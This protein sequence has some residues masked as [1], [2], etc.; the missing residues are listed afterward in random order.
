MSH[1]P[2]ASGQEDE[3]LCQGP[4]QDALVCT[5][6][7]LTEPLFTIL[8]KTKLWLELK[9]GGASHLTKNLANP[10]QVKWNLKFSAREYWKLRSIQISG[11]VSTRPPPP[12]PLNPFT[13]KSDQFHIFPAA[14]P[15]IL[16]HTVWRTWRFMAYLDERW[17]YYQF[18]VAS[19]IHFS[20]G[21]L[22]ECTTVFELGSET[23]KA[24]VTL[25]LN[26]GRWVTRKISC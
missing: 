2:E 4:P 19:H 7:C 20:L 9:T 22:G 3:G 18:S 10:K 13:P 21:R 8:Q 14:S 12:P 16:S 24:T 11:D 17:L 23:V 15:E 6:T 25:T 1:L 5:F 26:Q